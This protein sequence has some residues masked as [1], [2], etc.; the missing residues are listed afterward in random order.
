MISCN[1]PL[2]L[3]FV[4]CSMFV[5]IGAE[6]VEP[7]ATIRLQ[8]PW[9]NVFAGKETVFHATLATIEPFDGRLAWRF[10]VDGRTLSRGESAVKAGPT[11]TGTVEVRINVPAVKPGVIMQTTL[12]VSA[13]QTG[14]DKEVATLDRTLWVFP[15]DPFTGR[16]E[17]LKKLNIRLFDPVGTTAKLFTDGG[18]PFAEIRNVDALT[19]IEAG[20]LIVG[21]G[22]SLKEYRGLAE[23]LIKAAAAGRPV[24]C[25]ALDNGEMQLPV[26]VNPALPQP[27]SL[28]FH[29]QDII[30]QLDKR[31]D[32]G[33]WKR[34]GK[35]SASGL[36]LR[37]D[38]GPVMAEVSRDAGMWP[39]MEL[40]FEKENGKLVVCGF[41][42]VGAWAESPTPRFLLL[43][44]LEHVSGNK[45]KE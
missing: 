12:S 10:S 16:T 36:K 6:A 7:A 28:V 11:A 37:G 31:L 29:Q 42:I 22:V 33:G 30:T 20:T 15:E 13:S 40:G 45:E 4:L 9:S 23:N 39:W 41:G 24:L 44:V 21:E 17:W 32:A 38:R 25:L 26:S 34:N 2:C 5:A 19:S 35:A 3:F 8:E 43:K 14:S 1:K 27:T 18:V